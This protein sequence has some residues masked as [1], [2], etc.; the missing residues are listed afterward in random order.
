[1]ESATLE[2][3]IIRTGRSRTQI[4]VILIVVVV[5]LVVSIVAIASAYAGRLVRRHL[6]DAIEKHYQAK[7]E[8]GNFTVLVFPHVVVHG[9][10]LA[11]RKGEQTGAP[12]FIAVDRFTAEASILDLLRKKKRID[13]VTLEG[14]RINIGKDT[15]PKSREESNTG[16]ASKSVPEFVIDQVSADG[17]KLTI[18]PKDPKKDPLV[19]DIQKLHLKSA[20]NFTSMNYTATLTNATPPGLIHSQGRFG[21]LNTAEVGKTPLGGKYQFRDADLSVFKGISGRLSSDGEFTGAL[22]NIVVDGNTT[23][24]DF[25]VR[26]SGHP[27]EMKTQFHAVVDGTNG[28]TTLEPVNVSFGQSNL[29]AR[30]KVDGVP[31]QNGKAVALTVDAKNARV[32]DLLMMVVN[33]EP[34]LR[35]DANFHTTFVLSPGHADVLDRLQLRGNFGLE[36]TKFSKNSLQEKIA[37]LSNTARGKDHTPVPASDTASDFHG[38]FTLENGIA[39]FTDLRFDVPG[40]QVSLVGNF[41]VDRETLDFHGHIV[42]DAKL[43][44]MTT[45]VKSFF[46]KIVQPLVTKHDDTVVPIK[47]TGTKDDPKFGVQIGKLLKRQ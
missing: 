35:G 1:V 22:D 17:T 14:L 47:I 37:K 33:G 28:D 29:T 30:G 10:K 2:P 34:V 43:S 27:V 25:Q 13:L 3:K 15:Q 7:V 8:L 21:P 11:L 19:F 18:F 24:P 44:Q 39:R 26:N 32:E 4:V 23:I 6:A 20:G 41:N 40:A 12:P 42:M 36:E 16:S 9:E 31:G 5:A 45:G 46:A 38:N